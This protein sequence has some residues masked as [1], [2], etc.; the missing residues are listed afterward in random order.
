[1]I[2]KPCK[3]PLFLLLF[4]YFSQS[5]SQNHF[6]IKGTVRDQNE[7][8]PSAIISLKENANSFLSDENGRFE[9]TLEEGLY[10]LQIN[11][12][13]YKEHV[14]HIA[15]HENKTLDIRL[16]RDSA[17][18]NELIITQ[19]SKTLDIK[20][21]E[22]SINS[23]KAEDIQKM[24]VILG[25]SDLVK[26]LVQLP[27]VTNAGEGASGF[28]VRGGTAGQN[29]ILLD[30][31]S[32]FS[33]SHL[34]G[35]FS[36][37]NTDAIHDIKLYKGG[38]PA[39][40]GGRASS[41]LTVNQKSGD[42]SEFHGTGGI[43]V[44]SSRLTLHGPIAREK[45]SFIVSGR[46]SYAHL[47]LKLQDNKNAAYFYDLN[48]KISYHIDARNKLFLSGYF[49]RDLFS[50]QNALNNEFGNT[51]INLSWEHQF[52]SSLYATAT[53]NFSDYIYNLTLDF[54]KF[55][56]HSSIK[57]YNIS[58]DLSHQ[59]NDNWS[60]KY[61]T[62]NVLNHFFPGEISPS[63]ES[64]SIKHR[65][66][67]RKQA[68]ENSVYLEAEH[69][70][71]ADL[72]FNYGL[73]FTNFRR[74]GNETI[75]LYANDLPVTYDP[76]LE[77]YSEAAIT[78]TYTYAKNKTISSY[79]NWDPRVTAA[80]QLSDTESI[81]AG[82]TSMNQYLHLLSNTAA[83][84]PLDI[85]T[86]SGPY[87]KPERVHQ[88]ALGY[89]KNLK[90]NTYTLETEIYYKKGNNHID[91]IDGAELVGNEHIERVI[92]NGSSRAYGLEF[93][94]RKNSGKLTGMLSYTLSR[95][96]QRTPGRNTTEIGINNGEWYR[97]PH[98]KLHD[99]AV[100]IS[101][102][103]SDKWNFNGSFTLQSGRPATYPDSQYEYLG[104]RIPNFGLRNH[105]S[106]PAFHHLDFSCSYTPKPNSTKKW[107]SEWVF[108]V[109]NV[110]NR[111]NAASISFKENDDRYNEAVKL[112][113]FGI[114]P[115]I[116]YNFKF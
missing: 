47:F 41:V 46:S 67:E 14:E 9:I 109:Y 112:S 54:V 55:N 28:N 23:L 98:D 57:N 45:V 21:P 60:L 62:Q 53:V 92:L 73:R 64:S 87:I 5:F 101:Y 100:T 42:F 36:I 107:K 44:I 95:S 33:S 32:V 82:Y 91:Y 83:P 24:P 51:L 10:T 11:F 111:K 37:F 48:T 94:F 1:M 108:G 58:Y 63:E 69:R 30:K 16:D 34:F 4:L 79:H 86:P 88:W 78:D 75:N 65:V 43:G 93:L 31:A 103:L 56:W 27:G 52:S 80:F 29:L 12:L 116:T 18:L 6:T 49:G 77:I 26:A 114:V 105:Y 110:Y 22:M 76:S 7:S 102:T 59:I 68:W 25:E 15:L 99:L 3:H 90:Q 96:E 85:W 81:K 70:L 106:L 19:N 40:Y 66:F 50:F 39:R 2:N 8:L 113:I 20:K 38:V 74:F 115:S 72:T 35:F 17:L 13:G 104:T 84:T 97:T 61:G 89:F 71:T